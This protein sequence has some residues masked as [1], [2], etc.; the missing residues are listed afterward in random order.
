MLSINWEVLL[1]QAITFAVFLP[2][3]WFV[4]LK[5]LGQHLK[6]RSGGIAKALD[7]SRAAR[8]EAESVRAGA[9]REM[10]EFKLVQKKL[11]EE[12]RQEGGLLKEKILAQA[13]AE[14][15]NLLAK[16]RLDIRQETEAAR[17]QL[18]QDVAAL[19]VDSTRKL[20][21]EGMDE[22]AQ[23]GLVARFIRQI[24]RQKKQAVKSAE[25]KRPTVKTPGA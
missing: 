3:L 22:K 9:A 12:A 18:Q 20:L 8:E 7:E 21:K 10:E 24:P 19:V 14:Q 5:P 17:R 16:A 11:L 13:R 15:E 6:E 1:T 4:Y 25:K 2:L 23:E